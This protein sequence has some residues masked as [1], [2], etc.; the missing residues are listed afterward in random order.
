M[1]VRHMATLE[2]ESAGSLAA[3]PAIQRPRLRGTRIL[4]INIFW[5]ALSF[6]WAALGI[7]ILPS[8]VFK[9]AGNADK[10]VA[11]AF[12]LVP[13]AFVSLFANP[14]FGRVSDRRHGRLAAWGRRRPYILI[15]TLVNV[16]ALV[17]MAAARE[18]LSLAI[19]Y[20]LVQFSSNAAQ[21]PFHALLPDIVPEE[22]RGLVSGVMGLLAI[23]GTIAGVV[24]AG[25]FVAASQ[26]LPAYLQGLWLTY[27]IIIAVLLALMLIT[28]VSVRE[29][30]YPAVQDSAPLAQN[31][32]IK[33]I[34]PYQLRN[35]FG[36]LMV[37][38]AAWGIMQLWNGQL[39]G[40]HIS[41]GVQQVMLELIVTV[42]LLRLFDFNPR[43]DPDFAWVLL[44]RLVM[45]LGI[46]TVQDFLQFYMRDA[47]K[48]PHPEQQSTNF[49]IILSLTCFISAFGA[50]WLSVRL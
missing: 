38:G 2:H 6:H 44:T 34:R 30:K 22:Q 20:V 39:P 33:R 46:Y 13:G 35:V 36:T 16:A 45:M 23:A 12:V 40:L 15:V 21:A 11:L 5:L 43:R 24:V 14:L 1:E 3:S 19:A 41:S 47:V 9:I 26:P 10:G 28:I 18:I 17:W 37:A 32:W 27:A 50:G 49:I 48:A 31:H 42:G 7:I 25:L 4:S 8:Q 29:K